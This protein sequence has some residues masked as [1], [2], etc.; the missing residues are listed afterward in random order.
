V[1]HVET[2]NTTVWP[3]TGAGND[4][5]LPAR[6]QEEGT[7][8]VSRRTDYAIRILAEL[9]RRPKGERV[10]ARR[11][12]EDLFIPY[13]FARRIVTQ[14]NRAGFVTTRRGIGGGVGLARP[15]Q[16]INLRQIVSSLD[17]PIVFNE[18]THDP[19]TCALSPNC[20]VLHTWRR[21]DELIGSFLEA[22]SLASVANGP[23]RDRTSPP[24]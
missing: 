20:A 17:G 11:L 8:E 14:L 18:C 22:Q 6:P 1:G 9:A 5:R 3:L 15:A 13:A 10:S 24:A 16:D 2:R 12:G 23:V 21:A 19:A 4:S 7:T